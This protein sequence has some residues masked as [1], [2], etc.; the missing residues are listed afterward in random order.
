MNGHMLP[1]GGAYSFSYMPQSMTSS[2][3]SAN[4]QVFFFLHL[5]ISLQSYSYAEDVCLL[6]VLFDYH[7]FYPTTCD[8]TFTLGFIV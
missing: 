4:Q 2:K 3:E 5:V 8:S 1:Q 7:S 6:Y